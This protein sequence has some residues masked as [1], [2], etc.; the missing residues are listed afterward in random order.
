[1]AAKTDWLSTKIRLRSVE[2][3]ASLGAGS[4]G[5]VKR[6]TE[7]ESGEQVALKVIDKKMPRLREEVRILQKIN[8]L[9]GHPNIVAFRG[10]AQL[11]HP[12]DKSCIGLVFELMRGGELYDNL[13]ENGAF[14]ESKASLLIEQVA[15]ALAFLHRNNIVHADLKPENLRTFFFVSVW[16][17]VMCR[18]GRRTK[19]FRSFTDFIFSN[20]LW[21]PNLKER[22]FCLG[23]MFTIK[24]LNSSTSTVT[25]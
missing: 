1:V 18:W 2:S 22:G 3:K 19:G 20:S 17:V 9:G 13:V 8:S 10:M 14:S 7:A 24:L 23:C 4:F 11:P 5:I 15:A 12:D 16:V 25:R 6:A 21:F